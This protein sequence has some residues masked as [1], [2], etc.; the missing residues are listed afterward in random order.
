MSLCV[1]AAHYQDMNMALP[2]AALLIRCA[3][4]SCKPSWHLSL[5]SLLKNASDLSMHALKITKLV[6]KLLER[7]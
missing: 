3:K 5:Q 7:E 4:H 6:P 2:K 1:I